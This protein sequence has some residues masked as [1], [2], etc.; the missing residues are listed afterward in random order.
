MTMV[1]EH[2]MNHHQWKLSDFVSIPKSFNL[3]TLYVVIKGGTEM[4]VIILAANGQIAR[5]VEDRLLSQL[6][7]E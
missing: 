1:S 5:L 6:R 4:N 3:T 2:E 7:T